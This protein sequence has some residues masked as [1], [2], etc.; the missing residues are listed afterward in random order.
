MQFLFC[1][2]YSH[3]ESTPLKGHTAS[4][5]SVNFSH[6]SQY[7]VTASNDRLVKVWSIY[8]QSVLCTLSQHTHWVRC[9]K[10]VS[11]FLI[12][13]VWKVEDS[14]VVLVFSLFKTCCTSCSS[15][16]TRLNVPWSIPKQTMGKH[17]GKVYKGLGEQNLS[18]IYH[19]QIMFIPWSQNIAS[20]WFVELTI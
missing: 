15:S 7:L 3:G 4:V 11:I 19:N 14:T 16:G 13:P 5:R 18:T 1:F 2:V 12:V 8:S 6:D 9:A 17:G 10:W 20:H